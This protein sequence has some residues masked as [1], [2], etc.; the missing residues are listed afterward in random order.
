MDKMSAQN[1]DGEVHYRQEGRFV[2]DDIKKFYRYQFEVPQGSK[3]IQ[4]IFN[5]S[6]KVLKDPEKNRQL[7]KEALW[8]YLEEYS[9]ENKIKI[10]ST[11]ATVKISI[12]LKP[13]PISLA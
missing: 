3:E 10:M 11:I 12:S 4:F 6:P 9:K 5:Y 13:N 2:K 7:I 8:E 1:G